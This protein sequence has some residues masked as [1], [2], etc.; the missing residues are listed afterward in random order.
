V[1]RDVV[2]QRRIGIAREQSQ[3]L[4]FRH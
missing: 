3:R 2:S 4:G 1:T